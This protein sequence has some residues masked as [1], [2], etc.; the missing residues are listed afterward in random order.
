MSSKKSWPVGE[1]VS[2]FFGLKNLFP[3]MQ[4]K[5][6]ISCSCYLTLIC[7]QSIDENL[8]CSQFY[9][10]ESQSCTHLCSVLF[11]SSVVA[12]S[13]GF[14]AATYLEIDKML[15]SVH[16]TAQ[17]TSNKHLR[18]S[19]HRSFLKT[20]RRS[21]LVVQLPSLLERSVEALWYLIIYS[22]WSLTVYVMLRPDSLTT[23]TL[24]PSCS[25]VF[26]HP[27]FRSGKK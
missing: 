3:S 6:D 24:P 27:K 25:H 22:C 19:W 18:N 4:G 26:A 16:S 23:A 13:K 2:K 7:I 21:L 1:L 14:H 8:H 5:T 11:Y 15:I 20:E 17:M 10:N 12:M 9:F